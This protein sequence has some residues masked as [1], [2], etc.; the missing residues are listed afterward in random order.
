MRLRRFRLLP[1]HVSL[2]GGLLG[3]W[4]VVAIGVGV[5][6]VGLVG[7]AEPFRQTREFREV[8]ACDRGGHE[9]FTDEEGS[10]AGRRTYTT[11]STHTDADGNTYTSTTTHHEVTWR[12]AD[13]S[14]QARD[15]SSRFYS[16]AEEGQPVRLRLWRGEVV[17][18]EV[19]GAAQW[20]LPKS[21]STLNAWLYV[22]FLGLGILLWGLLFG[23]R[24]GLFMLAFRTFSWMFMSFQPVS[25]TTHALAYG[26]PTGTALVVDI[27]FALVFTGIAA[28]MLLATLDRW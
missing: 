8:V 27:V 7:A 24:D 14:R 1:L 9:C 4:L 3:R 11:T 28:G 18:V 13:G 17:G 2:P 12:R 16:K 10:V 22:A 26:L 15:V 5:L 23:W 21:G 25:L 6:V 20:F 19:M